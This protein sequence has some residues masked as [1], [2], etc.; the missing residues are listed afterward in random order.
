MGT[1]T[2]RPGE[3]L[4]LTH[5]RS[6]EGLREVPGPKHNPRILQWLAKLGAWWSDDETPWCGTFV[7]HCVDAVGIK[8]AKAW[9]RAKAWADWGQ[10]VPPQVGAVVVFARVGGGHVGFIV[11]ETATHYAVLGGNQ[12]NM[13]NVTNIQK[14]RMV[15]CRWPFNQPFAATPRLPKVAAVAGNGNEA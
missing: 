8:P 13:V 15:A 6:L 12:G 4:W 14:N 3:P 10:R 5:A 9:F 2:P 1:I 11:G 7:A